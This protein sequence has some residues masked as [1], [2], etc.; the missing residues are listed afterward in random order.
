MVGSGRPA[1]RM[2][3]PR[4][5]SIEPR[6]R[7]QVAVPRRGS[8]SADAKVPGL[9]AHVAG[10]ERHA[11]HAPRQRGGELK[12]AWIP[13]L[14]IDIGNGRRP[15]ERREGRAG[16]DGRRQNLR[17]RDTE[18]R[19]WRKQR[20]VA[21]AG[22]SQRK[23]DHRGPPVVQTGRA[24]H[25]RRAVARQLVR[26]LGSRSPVVAVVRNAL[27]DWRVRELDLVA[28]DDR[29][30][31]RHL[32]AGDAGL[33]LRID[34]HV[35]AE[36]QPDGQARRRPESILHVH[37]RFVLPEAVQERRLVRPCSR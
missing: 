15:D 1:A 12:H 10:L 35:V 30:P 11:G 14:G 5:N 3:T 25:H 13:E 20:G 2:S 4:P 34:L 27:R 6:G 22:A 16:R 8:K 28:R 31:H 21:D 7:R 36:A 19:G 9:A 37:G 29:Q 18:A 32:H 23:V 17:E 33:R 24:L 26:D